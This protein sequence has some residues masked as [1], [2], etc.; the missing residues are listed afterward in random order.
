MMH[1]RGAEFLYFSAFAKFA[2]GHSSSLLEHWIHLL[3][4]FSL[5]LYCHCK[6]VMWV[7]GSFYLIL[8]G[9]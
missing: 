5:V 3:F 9:L 1:N 8:F 6:N 2:V 7:A 4:M